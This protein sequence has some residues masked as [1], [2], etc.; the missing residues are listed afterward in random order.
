MLTWLRVTLRHGRPSFRLSVGAVGLAQQRRPNHAARCPHPESQDDPNQLS[1]APPP[2]NR[3]RN[4]LSF[5]PRQVCQK[6]AGASS[7]KS[8]ARLDHTDRLL[9]TPGHFGVAL[10]SGV[11]LILESSILGI[12]KKERWPRAPKVVTVPQLLEVQNIS[13]SAQDCE[14]P[15]VLEGFNLEKL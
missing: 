10:G 15:T 8:I 13:G 7:G 3:T 1:K 2:P 5:R 4:A 11:Q 14:A 12:L 9:V 6:A